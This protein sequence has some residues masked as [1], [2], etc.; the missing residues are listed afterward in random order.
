[1]TLTP[2]AELIAR[3]VAE[4]TAL[5]SFNVIGLEHAEAIA[6]G[7]TA[8][9]SPALLQISENAIAFR[10]SPEPLLAACREIARSGSTPLGIHL[11]HIENEELV[12]DILDRAGE[13]GV[14]SVMFDASKRDYADN[15]A[16]TRRVVERA[17]ALGVWVEAELG[18]IG[19]KDGAHAPGVR[20]DPSEA[21][22]FVEQTGVD[23][24]AVAVGSSH[25]M[26]SR[27]AELDIDLIRQLA[28]AVPVPLVLHGSSGVSDPVIATAVAAGIRKVNVGTALNIAATGVLRGS[29]NE[30]PD[31]VDP[32]IYTRDARAA[33][34]ELVRAFCGLVTE[35]GPA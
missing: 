2:T 21:A 3:V 7:A 22:R 13:F 14:G 27:S 33:M 32:R 10:G 34:M 12:E 15:V 28:A 18:Q 35:P 23:G 8:A 11:D 5:P 1:M 17:H 24:L 20:T 31:A 25:A 9:N 29:L 19:G 30:H 4:G 16:A 6:A 26:R